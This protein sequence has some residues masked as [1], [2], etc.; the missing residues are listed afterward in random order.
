MD[1]GS[2]VIDIK[3]ESFYKDIA[4]DVEK[5]FDTSNY[6]E[7]DKRPLP[8]SKNEK[9]V[10]LFKD[11]LGGKTTKEFVGL[12]AKTYACLMDD[13]SEHK[14]TKGTKKYVIKEDLCL[15]TIQIACFM[16][17]SY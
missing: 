12:R 13:D 17:K 1:A 16:I 7:D 11:E 15:K 5:W 9:V 8:I 2:F 14:K 6:D 10:G 4:N 3:T